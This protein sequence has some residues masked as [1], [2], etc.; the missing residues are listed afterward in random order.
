M[1]SHDLGLGQQPGRFERLRGQGDALIRLYLS[2]DG[3]HVRVNDLNPPG[4]DAALHLVIVLDHLAGMPLFA[5]QRSA[6]VTIRRKPSSWKSS[7]WPSDV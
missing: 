3:G 2:Q 1:R 5:V 4:I 6:F 7:G